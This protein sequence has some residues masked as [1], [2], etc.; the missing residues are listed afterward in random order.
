MLPIRS[1]SQ[2]NR[3]CGVH[4]QWRQI[5]AQSP[6][7][8]PDVPSTAVA[9]RLAQNAAPLTKGLRLGML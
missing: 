6:S 3:L 9:R 5:I 4:A 8:P 1:R 7:V 2:D